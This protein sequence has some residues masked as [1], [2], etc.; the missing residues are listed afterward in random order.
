MR[1]HPAVPGPGETV[2]VHH[3]RAPRLVRH[4]RLPLQPVQ[5]AGPG[6]QR[7]DPG[8]LSGQLRR[9]VPRAGQDRRQRRPGRARVRVDE[10]GDPRRA[11]HQAH[12]VEL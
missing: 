11:G 5:L 4:P 1:L 3:G 8:V 2:Q 10:E 6:L 9:L 7:R 12:Q